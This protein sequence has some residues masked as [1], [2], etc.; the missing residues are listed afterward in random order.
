MSHSYPTQATVVRQ[1]EDV[2]L[3]VSRYL[4]EFELHVLE[5]QS[6]LVSKKLPSQTL[7]LSLTR[8]QSTSQAQ[9]TVIK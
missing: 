1:I 7:L 4:G 6:S 3:R 9:Q 8:T 5:Q 2:K